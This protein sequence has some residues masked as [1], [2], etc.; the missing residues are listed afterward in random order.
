MLYSFQ[1]GLAQVTASRM[2]LVLECGHVFPLVVPRSG[3]LGFPHTPRDPTVHANRARAEAKA[4][5]RLARATIVS[6]HR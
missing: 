1:R 5:F 2:V 3:V 4:L 6:R